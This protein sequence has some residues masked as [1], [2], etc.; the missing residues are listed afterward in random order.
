[1]NFK[2]CS[3][4]YFFTKPGQ[5]LW[6]PASRDPSFL[7]P[8]RLWRNS[9]KKGNLLKKQPTSS[10]NVGSGGVTSLW[11]RCHCHNTPETSPHSIHQHHVTSTSNNF[12]SKT[13]NQM[14]LASALTALASC[15]GI[16]IAFAATP[17]HLPLTCMLQPHL[18]DPFGW[19]GM[20]RCH[21]CLN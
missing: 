19:E 7:E 15:H 18:P 17:Q 21:T 11:K 12:L 2:N 5:T 8:I 6:F 3:S 4:I 13:N 1:M 9:F 16:C 14:S 10:A 20:L